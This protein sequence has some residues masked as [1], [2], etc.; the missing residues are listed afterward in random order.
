MGSQPDVFG[1]C[2]HLPSYFS[3]RACA[4]AHACL[5]W[6][7]CELRHPHPPGP[8]LCC[9]CV[10]CSVRNKM[11]LVLA[12]WWL[13]LLVKSIFSRQAFPCL[14]ACTVGHGRCLTD[15]LWA[16]LWNIHLSIEAVCSGA[17]F[18]SGHEERRYRRTQWMEEPPSPVTRGSALGGKKNLLQQAVP[19]TSMCKPWHML[20]HI[21][22]H[23]INRPINTQ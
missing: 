22:A 3:T 19:L 21:H 20:T 16:S 12:F 6:N 8:A 15:R 1:L 14:T 10:R 11:A 7:T 5:K 4:C 17:A 18:M 2:W 23:K 13:H 9:V